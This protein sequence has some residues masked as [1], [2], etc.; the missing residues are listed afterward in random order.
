MREIFDNQG[1]ILRVPILTP[2]E[3]LHIREMYQ[4]LEREAR[5]RGATGRIMNMHHKVQ[6]SGAS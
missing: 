1:Y 2:D 5:E 3:G 6:T 4:C